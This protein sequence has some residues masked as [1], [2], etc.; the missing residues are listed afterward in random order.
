MGRFRGSESACYVLIL[1]VLSALYIWP[2]V[3]GGILCGHDTQ[4]HL[5]RFRCLCEDLSLTNIK[6]YVYS[7]MYQGAGYAAGAFYSDLLF[8]PFALLCKLGASYAF[9]FSLYCFVI[10]AGTVLSYYSC[11]RYIYRDKGWS[12]PCF[13]A[14]LMSMLML[15]DPYSFFN[16][17]VRGAVGE[18]SAALFIPWVILGVYLIFQNTGR[19]YVLGLAV[20]GLVYSHF[21][22]AFLVCAFLLLYYGFGQKPRYY[23]EHKNILWDTVK[24]AALCLV[25]SLAM[26]VPMLEMMWK[27]DLFIE[28]GIS[29]MGSASANCLISLSAPDSLG[30]LLCGALVFAVFFVKKTWAKFVLCILGEFFVVSNLFP[31]NFLDILLKISSKI[32]FPWRLCGLFSVIISM[33]FVQ[34][35][36][37]CHKNK[38]AWVHRAL[39]WASYLTYFVAI[40]ALLASALGGVNQKNRLQNENIREIE[41]VGFMEYAP[42]RAVVV[43]SQN[44]TDNQQYA[45]NQ[46]VI[47]YRVEDLN[48]RAFTDGGY[49]REVKDGLQ[50]KY[51]YVLLQD[52]DIVLPKLK[53]CGYSIQI[54]GAAVPYEE[55]E[56]GLITVSVPK[57]K[58]TIT[59]EYKGTVAQKVSLMASGFALLLLIPDVVGNWM[60]RKETT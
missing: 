60:R 54:N 53:Y 12:K 10:K 20:A 59:V 26:F 49:V 23:A 27:D 34:L 32:Q 37:D 44:I 28:A 47:S 45:S 58:G 16:Y 35:L 13:W 22:T 25:L 9:S 40:F 51:A 19:W 17:F 18:Y 42:Y 4:F 43:G 21:I 30:V 48:L 39:L 52:A 57:G 24:A 41:N 7:G 2:L 31:W 15:F 50:T 56:L 33:L 14:F 6:P 36:F 5:N 38:K 11:F 55:S 46:M 29:M 3:H 8:L 1:L